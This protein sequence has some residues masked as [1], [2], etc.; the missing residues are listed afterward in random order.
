MPNKDLKDTYYPVP[1]E[2]LNKL[3]TSLAKYK[4]VESSKGYKR[5]SEIVNNGKISYGQMNRVKNYFSNYEGE[6]NDSE[7]ILNGGEVMRNWV[8]NTLENS[9]GTIKNEKT[10]RMYAGEENQFIKTHKK[11]NDNPTRKPVTNVNLPKV[12]NSITNKS[13]KKIFN[14]IYSGKINYENLEREIEVVRYLIE[15]MNNNNKNKII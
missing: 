11:D 14:Q 7:Y 15:Y 13:N 10:A 3:K 2:V 9:T 8:N 5:A 1:P 4:N 12:T 6:G